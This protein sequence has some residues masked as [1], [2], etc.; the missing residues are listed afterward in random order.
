M[1]WE[2][3][4]VPYEAHGRMMDLVGGSQS[5]FGISGTTFAAGVQSRLYAWVAD[6]TAID[7][8]ELAEPRHAGLAAGLS[9]L[10]SRAGPLLVAA[11]ARQRQD[12]FPCG[13]LASPY[14]KNFLAL[15]N[16]IYGYGAPGLGQS[17]SITPSTY[18]SLG[19]VSAAVARA[20]HAPMATI[21]INDNNS[22][23]QSIDVADSGWKRGYIQNWNASLGRQIGKGV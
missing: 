13:L 5:I 1:R 22:S 4:G 7:R 14:E 23:T 21:P 11:L 2:Y 6:A 3:Y 19:Q 9:R 8:Q 12:R 18:Q 15:L 20:F 16:Q 10:R 17:Q